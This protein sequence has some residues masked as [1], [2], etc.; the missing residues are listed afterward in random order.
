MLEDDER[1]EEQGLPLTPAVDTSGSRTSGS[2]HSRACGRTWLSTLRRRKLHLQVPCARAHTH[3]HTHI[4]SLCRGRRNVQVTC[5]A[6]AFTVR[7]G[8]FTEHSLSLGRGWVAGSEHGKP[9]NEDTDLAT[10]QK[11]SST[12]CICDVLAHAHI[13][14]HIAYIVYLTYF[15]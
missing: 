1:R 11:G 13:C 15:L 8:A 3:T 14:N 4:P 2:L 12:L 9:E 6:R 7:A 5:L 10:V